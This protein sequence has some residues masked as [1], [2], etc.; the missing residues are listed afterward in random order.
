MA[1]ALGV[2]V[3]L[4]AAF[5]RLPQIVRI[6]LARSTAGLHEGM[7]RADLL[8]NAVTALYH[9]TSGYPLNTCVGRLRGL[10]WCVHLDWRS[11][12]A[13]ALRSARRMP[14]FSRFSSR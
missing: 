3:T 2:G 1:K 11:D 10:A 14:P 12:M 8:C 5:S 4:G 13:S 7:F 9:Y 6:I